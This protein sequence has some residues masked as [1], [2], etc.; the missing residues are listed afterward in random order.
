M[1]WIPV[2]GPGMGAGTGHVRPG[3]FPR[4]SGVKHGIVAGHPRGPVGWQGGAQGPSS[5]SLGSGLS[6]AALRGGQRLSA[7][8]A[9]AGPAPQ[10]VLKEIEDLVEG[11]AGVRAFGSSRRRVRKAWAAVTR[12]TW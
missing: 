5:A 8:G 11:Q 12:V 2:S 4:F 9:D 6:V 1:D 7:G 3:P 10:Q